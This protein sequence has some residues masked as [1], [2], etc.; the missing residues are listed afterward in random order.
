MLLV[1]NHWRNPGEGRWR[2]GP[3]PMKKTKLV[4]TGVRQSFCQQEG[5]SVYR[6]LCLVNLHL[7]VSLQEGGLY[8]GRSA[9]RGFAFTW[10]LHRG[11]CLWGVCIHEVLLPVGPAFSGVGIQGIRIWWRGVCYRG[12]S[13]SRNESWA[14][15]LN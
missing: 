4:F 12:K 15:P 8:P 11:A 9:S 14:E 3:S 7:R 10:D 1:A 5:V 2:C 13:T 6:G